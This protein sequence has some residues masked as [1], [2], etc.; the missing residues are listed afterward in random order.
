MKP[1]LESALVK[2]RVSCTINKMGDSLIIWVP[3]S[4]QSRLTKL[5]G[6]TLIATLETLDDDNGDSNKK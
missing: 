6:K 4:Q 2:V 5:R 3:K 1:V